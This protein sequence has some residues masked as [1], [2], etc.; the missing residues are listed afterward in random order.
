[1]IKS[2]SFA[3]PDTRHRYLSLFAKESIEADRLILLRRSATTQD[4]L[5]RYGR[6]DISLD[7]FPY[8]GTTTICESLWMGVPTITLRGDRHASC[9]GA[10]ILTQVGLEALIAENEDGY[11]EKAVAVAKDT[12]RLEDLRQ[13]MRDRLKKS[14]LCDAKGFSA[15]MGMAFRDMWI[16]WCSN[17]DLD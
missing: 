9:V 16:E 8:N 14:S 1:M 10:S 7:P 15:N 5:S 17:P 6:V 3:C 12:H 4:H 11:I 13:N 2:K